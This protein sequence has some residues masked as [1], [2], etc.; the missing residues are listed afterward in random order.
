L[1]LICM[2][3]GR[4]NFSRCPKE[5]KLSHAELLRSEHGYI[6]SDL[7]GAWKKELDEAPLSVFRLLCFNCTFESRN[8]L[9]IKPLRIFDKTKCLNFA[10]IKTAFAH[11]N[12]SNLL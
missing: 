9:I 5:T 2:P 12:K 10:I 8:G 4:G 7:R 6:E 3:L 11:L 1:N